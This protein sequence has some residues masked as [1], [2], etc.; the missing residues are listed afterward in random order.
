LHGHVTDTYDLRWE[1]SGPVDPFPPTTLFTSTLAVVDEMGAM[2]KKGPRRPLSLSM[3]SQLPPIA[4]ALQADDTD[5]LSATTDSN[6][7]DADLPP[8]TD[9][10]R[11][12]RN[13]KNLSLHSLPPSSSS[14]ALVDQAPPDDPPI[15]RRP[16]VA[17]LP[18]A[19]TAALLHRKELQPDQSAVPYADGPVQIL[20]SVWLGSEDNARDWKSLLERGIRSILNVAKEVNLPFDAANNGHPLRSSVSTPD[21]HASFQTDPTYVPPHVP[22]GRP[23]M[24][25]LKMQWSHGQQDLV[26]DGFPAAMA[27]TDAAIERGEGVLIQCVFLISILS[28]L[29][30]S[31]LSPFLCFFLF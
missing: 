31:D 10:P 29:H 25:Y 4:V 2:G 17:S 1:N 22:S 26:A 30:V 6:L 8:F 3:P 5:D 19:S 13:R 21:L 28:I 14:L 20:P 15:S 9:K 16:S 11:S 18:A 23:S 12:L 27:F 24:H 7:S